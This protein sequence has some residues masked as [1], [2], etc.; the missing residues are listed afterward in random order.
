M[1]YIRLPVGQI[2]L[3]CKASTATTHTYH[4]ASEPT[5]SMATPQLGDQTIIEGHKKRE[6]LD[7][8]P[9]L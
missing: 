8:C 9:V 2:L 1:Q 5:G 4:L 7:A 3:L 6:S